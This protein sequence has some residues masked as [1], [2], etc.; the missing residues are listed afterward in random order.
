M[1]TNKSNLASRDSVD[2]THSSYEYWKAISDLPIT[3]LGGTR[4]MKAAGKKYL[5]KDSLEKEA[6]YKNRVSRSTLVNFFK[7]TISFLGGQVFSKDIV[8]SDDA[9]GVI[10]MIRNDVD[11][12]GN[13]IDTFC[14]RH[15]EKGLGEGV[16]SIYVDTNNKDKS[17]TSKAEETEDGIRPYLRMISGN[18][19]FAFVDENGIL[20][21]VR[22]KET[23]QEKVG[24]FGVEVI[25]QI[26]VIEP[27][28]WEIYR[29]DSKKKTWS[30]YEAGT[31]NLSY[32]PIVAFIPGEQLSIL[33]GETPLIDLAELNLDH[34]QSKSDQ[35]NILHVARVPMLFCK[36]VDLSTVESSVHSA[37]CSDGPQAE[38]KWVEINGKSI[39]VGQKDLTEIEA[40]AA[41][42]G[43]QQLIPRSGNQTA[44]EKAITSAESNSSLG[45]W[46]GIEEMCIRRA[47][48]MVCDYEGVKEQ[49][50]Y[51]MIS[52]NKDFTAGIIDAE[53]IT[54]YIGMVEKGILSAQSAFNEIKKKGL[55]SEELD[56]ID[57]LAEMEN[58]K[59]NTEA[60]SFSTFGK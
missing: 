41:L 25:E 4:A 28:L 50:D 36:Q 51:S 60:T 32:I 44:T 22:I 56:W 57:I 14:K 12:N 16:C 18:D 59:Q 58:E 46:V 27:G 15:F 53:T 17:Y 6:N 38:I 10:N 42:Y 52:L 40:K 43:L 49:F 26:R 21:Q 24:K 20:L 33:T 55:L 29:Q 23:V 35:T 54:L 8:I 3:L 9:P 47:M 31:T 34:W 30:I 7:K 48:E 37:I 13:T 45:C 5:P 39:E 1:A 19:I 2:A 11:L